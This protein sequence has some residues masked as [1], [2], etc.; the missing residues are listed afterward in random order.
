MKLNIQYFSILIIS[1]LMFPMDSTAGDP[2]AEIRAHISKNGKASVLLEIE[3]ARENTTSSENNTN[4]RQALKKK[5]QLIASG[6]KTLQLALETQG[7]MVQRTYRNLPFLVTTVDAKGLERLVR[8]RGILSITLNKANRQKNIKVFKGVSPQQKVPLNS[9]TQKEQELKTRSVYTSGLF[10]GRPYRE[11]QPLLDTS[12]NYINADILWSQGVTG[13]GQVVAILDDGIDPQHDMFAGKIIAEAC[14]SETF[15]STDESLCPNGLNSEIGSGA[16]SNC[17]VGATVCEH[18]SHVAGAAA[19]NDQTGAVT[20]KGVAYDAELIPI[21]VFTKINDAEAC[22]GE[23]SCLLSYSSATLAALNH[24]IDLTETH[25]IASANMSLGGGSSDSA[26]DS[27]I[28]KSA[29]DTLRALGTLTAIAAGNEGLVGSVSSPGCI[30]TAIT[31]SSVIV[32]TADDSV[33]HAEMVD[34]LAPGVAIVSAIPNNQYAAFSGTSMAT[35]HVAGA[36]ALLKSARPTATAD[37]LENAL[38]STGT[39]TDLD[40]W[41]WSTPLINVSAALEALD[42]NSVWGR[43]IAHVYP[44]TRT[45][46]KSL[47]RIFNS[48]PADGIFNIDV[49]DDITGEKM[50]TYTTEVSG[51]ASIQSSMD[52]IENLMEPPL[53]PPKTTTQS[54][55]LY[56]TSTVN[57]YVQHVLW[58]SVGGSLT[59]ASGCGNK[60]AQD[61]IYLNNVHTTKIPEYPSYVLM[62]NTSSNNSNPIFRVTDARDGSTFGSFTLENDILPHTSRMI[63]VSDLVELFGQQPESDQ[64]HINLKL[65]RSFSGFVQHFVDN[66]E[67]GILTNMT[68]KCE[69]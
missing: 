31:V 4:P 66:K 32:A 1:Y 13:S 9:N 48:S 22:N 56:I 25:S 20:R 6:H 57:G 39:E 5:R 29:I 3:L 18:G 33:N 61:L 60:T 35:P 49:V 17:S 38:K 69:L 58:N 47:I 50:G 11:S 7:I 45:S 30:S 41:S 40:T 2:L 52:S 59:N 65:D 44:S 46:I 67:G 55:S 53:S 19:G 54:Y 15:D 34:L 63:Y 8:Q 51:G 12:V 37:A 24:L 23:S 36:I 42:G 16:A 21:Q 26:C 43:T 62:H 14:F 10:L 64:F 28:H 68:T 27:N